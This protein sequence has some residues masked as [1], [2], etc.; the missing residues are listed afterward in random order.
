VC[1]FE[2]PN[3]TAPVLLPH[4]GSMN[5]DAGSSVRA[6]ELS[7]A[8]TFGMVR[9]CGRTATSFPPFSHQKR[10]IQ[11]RRGRKPLPLLYRDIGS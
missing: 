11:A 1:S 3:D 9:V 2:E 8:E 7:K 10:Q 5:D 6:M 4:P